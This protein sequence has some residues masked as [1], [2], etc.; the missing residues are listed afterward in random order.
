MSDDA[1]EEYIPI[2]KRMS[3]S[4]LE[5]DWRRMADEQ[6]ELNN[7]LIRLPEI[8]PHAVLW[9]LVHAAMNTRQPDVWAIGKAMQ[10]DMPYHRE[11]KAIPY[12]TE[13]EAAAGL[14]SL[15]RAGILAART[16]SEARE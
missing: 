11:F 15:L 9:A 2:E 14:W 13:L 1:A 10:H 8:P 4:E 12:K 5:Q 16:T 3:R 6:S 7:A